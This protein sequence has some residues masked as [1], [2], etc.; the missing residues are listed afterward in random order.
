M[1]SSYIWR[2]SQDFTDNSVDFLEQSCLVSILFQIMHF[3]KEEPN[4]LKT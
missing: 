3:S 2:S 1:F 4:K